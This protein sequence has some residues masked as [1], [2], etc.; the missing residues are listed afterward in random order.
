M[1]D[2]VRRPQADRYEEPVQRL[3]LI[4]APRPQFGRIM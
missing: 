4:L 2:E 3:F 1:V